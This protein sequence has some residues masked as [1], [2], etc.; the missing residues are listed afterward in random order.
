MENNISSRNAYMCTACPHLDEKK[1]TES[2]NLHMHKISLKESLDAENIG[3]L[4]RRTL[5]VWELRMS[6]KHF[7]LEFLNCEPY[8]YITFS[9]INE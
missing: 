6:G 4:W 5:G 2:I 8:E 1:K 9:K 7:H 3:C